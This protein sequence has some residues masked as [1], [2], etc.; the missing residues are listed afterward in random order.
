MNI[1]IKVLHK[2]CCGLD[3]HR[4][5]ICARIG[6]TDANRRTEYKQAHFSSF[7]KGVRDLADCLAKYSYSDV[8]MESTGTYW[9]PV[10]NILEK[11]CWFTL[12]HPKYTKLQKGTKLNTRMPNGSVTYI[13][14]V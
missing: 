7:S 13:C 11:T 8:C 2:N 1:S 6:I 14:A 3:V 4:T 5:W 12:V 9:I 10:F